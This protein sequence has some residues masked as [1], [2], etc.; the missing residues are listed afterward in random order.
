MEID[1]TEDSVKVKS[2]EKEDLEGTMSQ[3]ENSI[4]SL[5]AAIET[6]NSEVADMKVSLK[7]AGES[8]KQ[9]NEIFKQSVSDQRATIEI[10]NKALARLKKFYAVEFVQSKQ[11]GTAVSPKPPAAKE[12]QKSAGA[13][14]VIQLIEKIII[15]DATSAEAEIVLEEQ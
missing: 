5:T 7:Q 2:N 14:G 13:G 11:P 3:L 1:E 10:L 15:K 4:A 8:R 12:Y 6:L 9:T